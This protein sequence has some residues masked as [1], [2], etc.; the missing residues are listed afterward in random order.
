MQS[1]CVVILKR[2]RARMEG[3]NSEENKRGSAR[4]VAK[5]PSRVKVVL[6]S[7]EAAPQEAVKGLRWSALNAPVQPGFLNRKTTESG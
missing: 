6:A 2:N 5:L 7:E 1:K 4:T 3:T